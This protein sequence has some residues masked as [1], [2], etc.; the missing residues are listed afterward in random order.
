MWKGLPIIVAGI[1]QK[2]GWGFYKNGGFGEGM[3]KFAAG[4]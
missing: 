3:V 2:V 4:I 1:P